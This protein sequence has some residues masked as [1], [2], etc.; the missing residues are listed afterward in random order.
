MIFPSF[1]LGQKKG[2][3]GGGGEMI[4]WCEHI[5]IFSSE[6]NPFV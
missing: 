3:G 6:V 5:C 1:L 4:F 2:G